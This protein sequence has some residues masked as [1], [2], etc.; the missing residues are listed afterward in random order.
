MLRI[1][2]KASGGKCLWQPALVP[3]NAPAQTL[4]SA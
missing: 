1:I 2:A 4:S 3:A